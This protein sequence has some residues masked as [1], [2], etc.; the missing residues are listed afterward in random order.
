MRTRSLITA[1]LSIVVLAA[2]PQALADGTET[3]GP[4]SVAL[5]NG[6]GVVVGGAGMQAFPDLPN[7]FSVTVPTGAIVK[8][9]LLYWEGHHSSP[10]HAAGDNM[11]SVNGTPVIGTLIG[12][13]TTFFA[14]S[15]GA[16]DGTE[17]FSAYRAD[18]TGLNL[19][20]AGAN[21]LAINDMLFASNF[22]TGSP[23][24]QGNDGA[25]VLVIYDDGTDAGVI[26]VRDGLDLA[27]FEFAPPLDTTVPQTFS[28]LSS[29][30][31]REASLATLAAS[32]SGPDLDVFRG[33]KLRV[34]FDV[35]AGFDI[36]DPWQS[37]QG[38]E[39][40]AAA[41]TVTIP[42]G[43]STM[44]V[45][46]LSEGGDRPASLSWIAA[47]LTIR[48]PPSS[49]GGEGCTPGYWK[50]H[51]SAWPAPYAPGQELGTVFSPTGLGTLESK[52]LY[53]ALK[54]GGG[55][56]LT[57]KK[58]NLLRIGVASLLNSAHSDVS[59]GMTPAQVIAAINAALES[60][61]PATIEALQSDLDQQNN[62]GC[63]LGRD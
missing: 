3:L 44:T 1:L 61:D 53:N 48:N 29:A 54:F 39:F 56:T 19:V 11:I 58:Q 45:Q 14:Q 4:P 55:S 43:A 38:D 40:D 52:T 36:L 5:A 7:S 30:A 20:S 22:P 28:F 57:A 46:A 51:L 37:A 9:V 27:Y 33:T 10:M 15:A 62:A 34:S 49:G 60:D 25:G 16:E 23:F 18:I 59:F 47:S 35:G 32:V 17:D 6:T 31:D 13:P 42:A 41:S 12:G 21:T 26:G 2:A 63:P 24:N 50:N 8:Q